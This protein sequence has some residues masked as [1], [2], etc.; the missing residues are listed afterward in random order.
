MDSCP[1]L[2][3]V[4]LLILIRLRALTGL[5]FLVISS[6][7]RMFP[8]TLACETP[9]ASLVSLLGVDRYGTDVVPSGEAGNST[10]RNV[11]IRNNS[12]ENPHDFK[13]TLETNALVGGGQRLSVRRHL[14]RPSAEHFS[15]DLGTDL[16]RLCI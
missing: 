4:H 5:T 13:R 16:Q 7:W 2:S 3:T 10:L 12:L 6:A 1:S 14:V 9:A 8:V 11:G 15:I